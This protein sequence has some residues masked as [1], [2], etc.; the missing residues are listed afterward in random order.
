MRSLASTDSDLQVVFVGQGTEWDAIGEIAAE[1]QTIHGRQVV[2]QVPPCSP[3]RV[4]HLLA[5]AEGALVSIV[6]GQGYDFAYPTKVLASLSAGK[7]VLFAGRGPV[8]DDI[9]N[10]G[11]GI[12]TSHDP[13]SAAEG[14]TSLLKA[15]AERFPKEM[16]RDWVVKN[17]SMR[18]MGQKATDFLLS[19]GRT[20]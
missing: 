6:P 9:D 20:R 17:R 7:P 4:A 19:I 3:S 1:L 14:M 18:R 12:A 11:L 2:V 13:V 16:L 5:G 15:D 10:A 8:V